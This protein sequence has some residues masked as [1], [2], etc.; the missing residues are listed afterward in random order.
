MS[1]LAII[2]MVIAL[3]LLYIENSQD[4]T[5]LLKSLG[6][7]GVGRGFNRNTF[8][9]ASP[10][11]C[12]C[13]PGHANPLS[14][15]F[16]STLPWVSPC[17]LPHKKHAA[18]QVCYSQICVRPCNQ[19]LVV[20]FPRYC[21]YFVMRQCKSAILQICVRLRNQCLVVNFPRYGY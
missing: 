13:K 16:H 9:C 14:C 7:A 10:C 15:G 8:P 1:C 6:R 2:L 12:P 18:M 17:G 5:R 4:K 21:W 20:N 19:C 3:F 11:G